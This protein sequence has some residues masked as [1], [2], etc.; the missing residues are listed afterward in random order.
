MRHKNKKVV[1]LNL[2]KQSRDKEKEKILQTLQTI[3]ENIRKYEEEEKKRHGKS[4]SIKQSL[5]IIGVGDETIT[6]R[7]LYLC[8]LSERD[9]Q[10]ALKATL[11]EGYTI[12]NLEPLQADNLFRLLFACGT[13][14]VV[15]NAVD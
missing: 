13:V 1:D 10:K 11:N 15:A 12:N 5:T 14:S 8:G 7:L 9:V 3:D 4:T 2:Y 6:A